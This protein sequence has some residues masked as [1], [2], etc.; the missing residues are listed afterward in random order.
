MNVRNLWI[1]L[2]SISFAACKKDCDDATPA[3]ITVTG[4]SPAK[5]K[6][7]TEIII[8]GNNFSTGITE[9]IVKFNGTPAEVSSATATELRV[10][11]PAGAP[12]GKIAVTTRSVSAETATEFEYEY[13]VTVST[14]AG[15]GTFGFA[16]A[17]GTA[18]KFNLLWGMSIDANDNIF[19]ADR[20]NHCIRKIDAYGNVSVFAGQPQVSGNTDG[21]AVSAKF[22]NTSSVLVHKDGSVYVLSMGRVSKIDNSTLMVSTIASSSSSIPAPL[23]GNISGMGGLAVADNGIIYLADQ[24]GDGTIRKIVPGVS[25]SNLTGP[26]S[27][28]S[29]L[30]GQPGSV[31]ITKDGYLL[32]PTTNTFKVQKV[33]TDGQVSN[34]A[35]NGQSAVTDGS[36]TA[37]SFVEPWGIAQDAKGNIFIADQSR[38]RMFRNGKVRTLTQGGTGYQDGAG[39]QAKFNTLRGIAVNS[40]GEIF[41]SDTNNGRIRKVVAE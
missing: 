20:Y 35:G 6:K 32:V 1:L 38:V 18:A 25:F 2:I 41:V 26:D 8:T 13:T 4:F 36:L 28:N 16:N 29:T 34:F 9:N 31:C 21:P 5:A 10:K 33:L 7:G 22:Y 19:V 3:A 40:K 27:D 17:K 37:A 30:G 23:T 24:V 39:E 15:D 14:V 11:V 12:D